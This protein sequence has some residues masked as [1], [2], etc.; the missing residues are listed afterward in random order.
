MKLIGGE[1]ELK[2]NEMHNYLTDSGRSSLR[3]ILRSGMKGKKYL[4]PDYLC[5]VILDIFDESGI[6]YDFYRINRDLTLNLDD[7]KSKSYDAIYLINYFGQKCQLNKYLSEIKD[8]LV[9]E[10]YAFSPDYEKPAIID[11]W[12]GFNSFRKFSILPEGSQVKS[13]LK[14]D[15]NQIKKEIPPFV[16]M[17]YQAKTI[18]YEYLNKHNYSENAYLDLF[19]RAEDVLNRQK[20]IYSISSKGLAHLL[21]FYRNLEKE[22]QIRKENFLTLD[23]YL[24][25]KSLGISP[26]YYSFY[27]LAV[28]GR[29]ELRKHLFS[30]RIFLPV[31]WPAIKGIKNELYE[32]LISIPVDSR[33][34][35]D[36]MENI[37][38][39][40][41]DYLGRSGG[42]WKTE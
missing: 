25:D 36:D 6:A 10:D 33:Y 3:L 23:K 9:I 40:I 31:H 8:K 4:L 22:Y 2:E 28:D 1:A 30:K 29:D 32:K 16:E 19:S 12:I 26:E 17:K 5:K 39:I 15:D 35:R 41:S 42:P 20:D 21:K 18:K 38:R 24:K 34:S 14:L 7:L 37:A 11:E 27:V 13:S